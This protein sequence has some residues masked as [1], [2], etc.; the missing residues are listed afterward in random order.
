VSE[1]ALQPAVAKTSQRWRAFA[2]VV[3]LALGI[4]VWVSIV[5]LPSLFAGRW[6]SP[7]NALPLLVLVLG[8]WRR[9]ELLLLLLFPAALLLPVGFTP[10]LAS[11]HVYGPARF[12]I[13]SVGLI[14]YLLGVSF[15]TSFYEP[16]PPESTRPLASAS[17]PQPPRWQRRYRMYWAFTILSVVFP[18]TLLYAA[19]FDEATQAF[20]RQ[21]YP[22]RTQQM[23]AVLDLTVIV[24][25][26]LLYGRFFV[27]LLRLHR[28]GDPDLARRITRLRLDMEVSRPKP[29]PAFYAGVVLAI[30]FLLLFL[31]TR[32]LL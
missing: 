8:L 11:P 7:G 5:L 1:G 19:N 31:F 14:A 15:F 24:A 3:A 2:D 13:V 20:L 16:P 29:R 32:N 28:T 10:E 9:S 26:V 17:K 21:M 23:L 12:I 27:G 22:A 30:G 18:A 4:N 25:W 6:T